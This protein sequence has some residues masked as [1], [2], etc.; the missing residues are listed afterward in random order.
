M[1]GGQKVILLLFN[2][3]PLDLTW[4]KLTPEVDAIM[5][6]YAL[7]PSTGEALYR[8]LTA[9][10]AQSVPAGRLPATWPANLQQ[11]S[12]ILTFLDLFV[13]VCEYNGLK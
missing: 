8:S 7:V 1:T 6:C 10:D 5:T 13:A 12:G 11:V 9:A 3:N 2:G 4:A